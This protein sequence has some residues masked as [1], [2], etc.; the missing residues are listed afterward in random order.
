EVWDSMSL[1]QKRTAIRN[2]LQLWPVFQTTPVPISYPDPEP[3][4]Y[5]RVP[6]RPV[7]FKVIKNG[8]LGYFTHMEPEEF[9]DDLPAVLKAMGEI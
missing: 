1:A 2:T 7:I 8:V 5:P 4:I 6:D 3:A 9:A